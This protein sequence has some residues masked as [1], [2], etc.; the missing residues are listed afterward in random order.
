MACRNNSSMSLLPRPP[1]LLCSMRRRRGGVT[2]QQTTRPG[3]TVLSTDLGGE[4]SYLPTD[5]PCFEELANK[6]DQRLFKAISTNK[7]HVLAK[8]LPDIKTTG[9][10]LRPRAHGYVLPAKDDLNF[11][12]RVLYSKLN[13]P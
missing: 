7:N 12:S 1:W 9:Y 4:A 5:N 11:I 10:N 2:P 8:Y 13:L 3:L 6:A